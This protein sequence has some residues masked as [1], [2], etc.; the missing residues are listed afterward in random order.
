MVSLS[1]YLISYI[2]HF[3]LMTC[4]F[5]HMGEIFTK[6]GVEVTAENKKEIDRKIH[7]YFG[8]EYK[9]CSQTWK[10][11]KER[12]AEDPETFMTGLKTALLGVGQKIQPQNNLFL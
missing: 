6:L 8:V 12:R 2:F 3:H 5:R 10:L 4:Y 11:I 1:P 9:N 7:E